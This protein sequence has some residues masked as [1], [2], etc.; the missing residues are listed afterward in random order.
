MPIAHAKLAAPKYNSDSDT[1]PFAEFYEQFMSFVLYQDHGAAIH[2]LISNALGRQHTFAAA[3]VN[4]LPA[5]VILREEE[6]AAFNALTHIVGENQIV[7]D[8]RSYDQLFADEINLDR[9]LY[10]VLTNSITGRHRITIQRVQVRSFVQAWILLVHE[11]GASNIKRKTDLLITLQKLKF[12]GDIAKYR[13]ETSELITNIYNSHVTVEDIIIHSIMAS[14]P[15]DLAALRIVQSDTIENPNKTIQDVHA[16]LETTTTTLEITGHGDI[17]AKEGM[18]FNASGTQVDSCTRCG[19]DN[20]TQEECYASHHKN[21]T[22]LHTPK[23][24]KPP[25]KKGQ[26]HKATKGSTQGADSKPTG[27]TQTLEEYKSDLRKIEIL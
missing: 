26:A 4:I 9:D 16:F 25:N 23:A 24:R 27:N 6:V 20:H 1:P 8:I 10:A 7:R 3:E 14:L 18:A 22:K 15:K 21:G 13:S 12:R 17:L 11:L 2:T 5:E 19:R